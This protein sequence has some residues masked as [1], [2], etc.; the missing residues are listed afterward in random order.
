MVYDSENHRFLAAAHLGV[1]ICEV[2]PNAKLLESGLDAFGF[3]YRFKSPYDVKKEHLQEIERLAS[4]SLRG[5]D[6][7]IM[8]MI[9][10]NA[11][12]F[13]DHHSQE[14]REIDFSQT[15]I[16]ILKKGDFVDFIPARQIVDFSNSSIIQLEDIKKIHDDEYIIYAYSFKDKADAKKFFKKLNEYKKNNHLALLAKRNWYKDGLFLPNGEKFK[17]KLLSWYK[18]NIETLGYSLVEAYPKKHDA[19]LSLCDAKKFAEIIHLPEGVNASLLEVKKTASYETAFCEKKQLNE[20]FISSLQSMFKMLN[21]LGFKISFALTPFRGK[22]KEMWYNVIK[23]TLDDLGVEIAENIDLT[24]SYELVLYAANPMGQK[25][26][27]SSFQFKNDSFT[28]SF[29]ISLERWI[30]LVVESGVIPFE[31]LPEQV[32]LIPLNKKYH[33]F[34]EKLKVKLQEKGLECSVDMST[35]KLEDKIRE[36]ELQQIPYISVIGDK[37]IELDIVSIRNKQGKLVPM[38]IEKLSEIKGYFESQ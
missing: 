37:E 6:Y 35:A 30:A 17:N 29:I 1:A 10:T 34:A 28:S 36:S 21:M 5:D 11:K 22:M 27:V 7:R 32:R 14:L 23:T 4:L 33:Q 2:L 15:T 16:Y 38:S 8:E 26:P 25:W 12:E 20:A 13:L 24:T 19:F 18:K 31:L 3:F 9:P